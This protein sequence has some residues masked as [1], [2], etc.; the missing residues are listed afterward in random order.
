[1][2]AA[3]AFGRKKMLRRE[4]LRPARSAYVIEHKKTN[5]MKT[6]QLSLLTI[7]LVALSAFNAQAA[8]KL[9][10]L[11]IISTDTNGKI[12]GVG[13]HRFKTTLHG[14]QPC[15]FLVK[16]DDP[17]GPIINGPGPAQNGIDLSLNAGR[18][19]YTVFAEKYNS[20]TWTNYT[21][22]F[23]F[24]LSMS[25]QISVLAPLNTTSTQFFPPFAANN[26]FTDDLNGHSVK[27]PGT[28]VYK[29]GQT[30]VT[31]VG[32]HFSN[33]SLFNK[34]RVGPF[35]AKS[36]GT[37]DYVGEFTLEVKAP[38]Q[39]AAGGVVNG[40]SFTPKVAP[41]S[42]F[43]IFG[44]D[45]S[46][47][48]QSAS[49][50]P[51]PLNL[52]GAS[53]TVGGKPAP[54]VFVSPV[55]INAQVPY[56]VVEAQAVPVVVTM[57]GVSSPP[58]NVAIISAAPGIFQFGQKRAVMQNADYSV[59]NTD[60]PA[61][62]DSYAVA[63]LTGSGQLDNPVASGT[64]AKADP[65]SRPRGVVTATINDVHTEVAF[66]GLTPEYVGLM[67]VNLKIPNLAPGSYPLV[68]TVN[69]EKSNAAMITV[70]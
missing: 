55:Q 60:N 24:D 61:A 41:G 63:Y 59:N 32:F 34:D 7:S 46:A 48:T 26:E 47:V 1:M 62:V 50:L 22:Q 30:E 23:H 35:E 33:P 40:G 49:S 12:Q 52:A 14:G 69:G 16:G 38:P 44:S 9:T 65:I 4:P 64:A 57:N 36:N 27:A 53:V 2:H 68:I 51:L 10:A 58:V 56:E 70:K 42:L 39:I 43:S 3:A 28:L 17:D 20:S 5:I 25:A 45:L 21:M 19:T 18:H 31:L 67:Q 15:I 29:S 13:A 8:V 6:S 11:Q 37:L 66:G 54:L